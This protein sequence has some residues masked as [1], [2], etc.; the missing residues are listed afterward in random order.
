[1]TAAFGSQL[2][3]YVVNGSQVQVPTSDLSVPSSVAGSV[4]AV[5][6]LSSFGHQ[7]RTFDLGAPAGFI[8]GTPCS[9]HYGAQKALDLPIPG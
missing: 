6:G 5:T 8:N 1:M 2:G 4:L 7:V 9:S 3:L